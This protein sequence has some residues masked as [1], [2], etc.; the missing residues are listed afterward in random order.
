MGTAVGTLL[1]THTWITATLEISPNAPSVL[2]QDN[3]SEVVSL[4]AHDE[5]RAYYATQYRIMESR[6]SSKRR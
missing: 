5:R 2:G 6:T 3:M 1:S 4:S